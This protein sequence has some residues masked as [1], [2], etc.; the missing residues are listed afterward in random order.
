MRLPLSQPG[1]KICGIVGFL[2]VNSVLVMGPFLTVTGTGEVPYARLWSH[3]AHTVYPY[4]P[5]YILLY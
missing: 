1:R 2:A 4:A 3:T 5:G